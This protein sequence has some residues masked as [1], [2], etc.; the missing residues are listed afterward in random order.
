MNN[1]T[2]IGVEL[3]KVFCRFA[4]TEIIRFGPMTGKG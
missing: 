4:C 1:T 2:V 3:A